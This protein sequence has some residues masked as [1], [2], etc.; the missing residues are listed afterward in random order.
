MLN[1][2]ETKVLQP[3]Q[4]KCGKKFTRDDARASEFGVELICS[5]CHATALEIELRYDRYNSWG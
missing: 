1:V 5:A 3:L 2:R 4:C